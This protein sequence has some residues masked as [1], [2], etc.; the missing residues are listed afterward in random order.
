MDKWMAKFAQVGY[1][2]QKLQYTNPHSVRAPMKQSQI[3]PVDADD[4]SG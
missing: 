3:K 4:T 2:A 1:F